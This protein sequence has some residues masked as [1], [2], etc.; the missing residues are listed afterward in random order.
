MDNQKEIN[1]WNATSVPQL[2]RQQLFDISIKKGAKLEKHLCTKEG[3]LHLSENYFL[4]HDDSSFLFIFDACVPTD[5]L[6]FFY[7]NYICTFLFFLPSGPCGLAIIP[8]THKHNAT[9]CG[10]ETG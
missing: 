3:F 5:R 2:F 1:A 9:A 7:F 6:L 10:S 8:A 4:I